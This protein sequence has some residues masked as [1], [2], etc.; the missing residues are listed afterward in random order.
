MRRGQTYDLAFRV[1]NP[2][3]TNDPYWL[4]EESLAFHEPTR[5][6]TFEVVFLGEVPA[7]TWAFSG[8]TAL[9]RP[10]PPTRDTTLEVTARG[11][12]AAQFR[13]IYGGLY[14]GVAW[15]W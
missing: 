10:G 8:L 11:T 9:E 4:H 3:P 13:D 5:F 14:C 7:I 15:E 6:A 1:V 12:T 2:D